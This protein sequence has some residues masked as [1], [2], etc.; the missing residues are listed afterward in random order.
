MVNY[1]S[2]AVDE[3]NKK[4][5]SHLIFKEVYSGYTF[6]IPPRGPVEWLQYVLDLKA[7]N[8]SN[9]G[10]LGNYTV[11]VTELWFNT[12]PTY[13]FGSLHPKV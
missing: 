7:T 8:C 11:T 10:A 1:F 6:Y 4:G 9:L 2:F 12:T 13:N 3:Y 5:E